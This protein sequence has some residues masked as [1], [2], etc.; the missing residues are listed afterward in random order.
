MCSPGRGEK[1]SE[2]MYIARSSDKNT[3]ERGEYGGAVTSILHCALKT[4]KVDGVVTVKAKNNNRYAGVPVLI[5]TPEGL[6]ETA[7]SLHCAAPNISRFIKEYLDGSS[8][9]KLAV[10]GK[11]CDI[12]AIIELQK[13]EQIDIDNVILIGLNC[14]GTLSPTV[15][16]EMFSEEFHVNPDTVIKE[17]IDEGMLTIILEDGTEKS[18]DLMELEK[19]GYGRRE[20]CRRCDINIPQMADVAC[21]KWGAENE[22][23]KSTFIEICSE[24]GKTFIEETIEKG[25]IEV[26]KPDEESL[27]RRKRKNEVEIERAKEWKKS[28]FKPLK[29]RNQSERLNYWINEFNKCIKCYGCRDACPICYCSECLLEAKRGF[30][31]KGEVPP[32]IM[33]P[34]TRLSHVA[35]SCINCGQCQD[36]CPME[37]PLSIL[38]SFL[39]NELSEIFGYTP[40]IDVD[41]RPPL[42]TATDEEIQ[43]EDTFLDISSL[44]KKTKRLT[45]YQIGIEKEVI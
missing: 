3:L 14:T 6:I 9:M 35:H 38:C 26:R 41:E 24:K 23:E 7:G 8:T 37:L 16:R 34:L 13:R 19:R 44:R 31:N 20:N 43:I 10:V 17:D 2:N 45:D 30:V 25:F 11:P 28:D 15:A 12:R 29:E 33:F 4:G 32:D 22:E 1:M 18:R 27:Q 21:G 36:G 39:H 40:G 5:T 42:A